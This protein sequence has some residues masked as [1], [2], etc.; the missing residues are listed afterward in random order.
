MLVCGDPGIQIL[1]G[2]RQATY[3]VIAAP[4]DL[5]DS[6]GRKQLFTYTKAVQEVAK[7]RWWAGHDGE[8]I[9]NSRVLEVMIKSGAAIGK[10]V[11]PPHELVSGKD[12]NGERVVDGS[13]FALSKIK[14][15]EAN[16]SNVTP[17][18]NMLHPN[19]YWSCCNAGNYG[20]GQYKWL[21]D[22]SDG[23][24]ANLTEEG[25][26]GSVRPVLIFPAGQSHS[27]LG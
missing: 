2:E 4:N 19:L 1:V 23:R 24:T 21:T 7:L 8:Y 16:F 3:H 5:A 20:N 22:F 6:G 14:S 18:E 25:V 17:A 10:W 11:I 12:F 9:E 13:L 27:T 15:Q 26:M